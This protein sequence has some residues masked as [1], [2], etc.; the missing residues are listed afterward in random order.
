RIPDEVF[1]QLELFRGEIDSSLGSPNVARVEIDREVGEP[2]LGVV[3][4][5]GPSKKRAHPRKKLVKAK[6]LDEVVVGPR[7]EAGH[8]VGNSPFRGEHEDG[9]LA[10]VRPKPAAD[11][12]AV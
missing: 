9:Q 1:D 4:W 10:V 8:P 11:V 3:D 2:Q 5:I 6:G 12:E 7:V